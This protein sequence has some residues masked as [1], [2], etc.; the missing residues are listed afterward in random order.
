MFPGAVT[1]GVVAF[2]ANENDQREEDRVKDAGLVMKEV[3]N[4]PDDIPQDLLDKAECVVV[5]PSVEERSVRGGR[6]LRARRDDLPQR[7]ALHG[8]NGELRHSHSA[9]RREHWFPGGR[10]GSR[11]RAAGDESQGRGLS[12]LQQGEAG[13]GCFLLPP[14]PRGERREGAT[15]IRCRRRFSPTPET[16]DCSREFPWRDPLCVPMEERTKKL[17]GKKLT[18]KEI[19]RGGK[20]G[21]FRRALRNWF[22]LL[23]AKSPTNKSDP[24]SLE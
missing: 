7:P 22:L 14:V 6:Q 15:D 2:I 13:C 1:G 16:K 11:V 19:I 17:Y 10:S 5:L 8:K 23:D 3:L 21:Q 20:V 24:K 4:L 12:S 18:A 9:G